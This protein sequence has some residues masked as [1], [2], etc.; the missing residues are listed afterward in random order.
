[1][2]RAGGAGVRAAVVE[3]VR[4]GR[5]RAARAVADDLPAAHAARPRAP[6][7]AQPGAAAARALRARARHLQSIAI[8]PA[9]GA[10]AR[11]DCVGVGG[12]RHR[13]DRLGLRAL[14]R[15]SG[16]VRFVA[17][18]LRRSARA[19]RALRVRGAEHRDHQH[20]RRGH[21]A[22]RWAAGVSGGAGGAAA[23]IGSIAGV[24]GGGRGHRGGR[25][26]LLSVA[27]AARA[28]PDVGGERSRDRPHQRD[29]YRSQRARVVFRAADP[30]RAGPCRA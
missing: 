11:R 14:R 5:A 24:G 22:G 17:D 7:R 16:R 19:P 15:L 20:D 25:V 29:V 28:Q 21:G 4:A 1:M 27:D 10:C 2:A 3:P 8:A 30:D 9:S 13:G 6:D 12:V 26:R 18:V 23:W